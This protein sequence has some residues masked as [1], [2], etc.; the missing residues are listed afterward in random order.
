MIIDDEV[1][2]LWVLF[3]ICIFMDMYKNFQI[4]WWACS[5]PGQSYVQSSSCLLPFVQ[6]LNTEGDA[7]VMEHGWSKHTLSLHQ[8]QGSRSCVAP[9]GPDGEVCQ[10]GA[11]TVDIWDRPGF[12]VTGRKQ[13]RYSILKGVNCN[14]RS[15]QVRS[16]AL[17][18]PLYWI[19]TALFQPQK[20]HGFPG[21]IIME[22]WRLKKQPVFWLNGELI[23]PL[24]SNYKF[25]NQKL[26]LI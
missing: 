17:P 22:L 25:T 1:W 20:L 13:H 26:W 4:I 21:W 10:R 9:Y 5:G 23:Q 18:S 6:T 11:V 15:V 2:S 16:V 12:Y 8:T 19:F 14:V 3:P 7:I 24:S